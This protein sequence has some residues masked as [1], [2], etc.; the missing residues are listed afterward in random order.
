MVLNCTMDPRV[1]FYNTLV[2]GLPEKPGR[3]V[4]EKATPKWRSR[5][6]NPAGY[7]KFTV[8]PLMTASLAPPTGLPWY[9]TELS[10]RLETR[11]VTW[12]LRRWSVCLQCGRPK[13]ESWVGKIPWRRKWQ[14]ITVLLPWKSHGRRS[15][16]GYSPW[17]RKESDTTEWLYSHLHSFLFKLGFEQQSFYVAMDSGHISFC[18]LLNL[19]L[20]LP[21]TVYLSKH[22]PLSCFL[23][24]RQ[25]LIYWEHIWSPA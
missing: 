13:F 14:S 11:L 23:I 4:R 20:S 21:S 2:V 24:N 15:L 8:L 5:A 10:P 16:V 3:C 17:G 12:W 9:H 6:R 19:N 7:S 1:I 25:M 18:Q 22:F